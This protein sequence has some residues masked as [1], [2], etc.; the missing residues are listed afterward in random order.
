MARYPKHINVIAHDDPQKP[1][2]VEFH[3]E[4]TKGNKLESIVFSKKDDGMYQSDQHELH[5]KLVQEK[6]MT[7]EFAQDLKDALWVAWGD[8]NHIPPCPKV[9]PANC[10]D[11]VFWAEHSA[12]NNLTV[13]NT[14]PD[15][16]FFSFTLNFVDSTATG[17]AK[18]IPY[19]PI[20]ENQNGGI[21]RS[22]LSD[23]STTTIVVGVAVVAVLGFV[24]LT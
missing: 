16:K 22:W 8:K 20:G 12:P 23:V 7:L 4:D 18:L 1:D 14:N 3:L 11:P 6:G 15:S 13:I 17:A 19:D 9:R 5:F 10:P 2:G 24:L 21:N